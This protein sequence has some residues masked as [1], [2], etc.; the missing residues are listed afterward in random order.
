MGSKRLS[1]KALFLS[2]LLEVE[3]LTLWLQPTPGA[4]DELLVV[5]A[6]SSVEV[7]EI[8]SWGTGP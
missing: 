8:G 2:L 7:S 1:H 5:L 3:A 6:R 4:P